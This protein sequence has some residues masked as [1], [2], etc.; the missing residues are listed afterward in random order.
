MEAFL[1]VAGPSMDPRRQ[2]YADFPSTSGDYDPSATD[3]PVEPTPT[4]PRA[5]RKRKP[6]STS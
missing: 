2:V 5:A 6:R 4:K 1:G 3:E